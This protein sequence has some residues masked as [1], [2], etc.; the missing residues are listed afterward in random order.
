MTTNGLNGNHLRVLSVL[1]SHLE[2]QLIEMETTLA[3]SSPSRFA[4][5]EPDLDPDQCEAI[6]RHIARLRR[7]MDEGARVLGLE[8]ASGKK[9]ASWI[10][11]NTLTFMSIALEEDSPEA[12][13]GYGAL[14]DEAAERV[15]RIEA[16]LEE[17]IRTCKELVR[18]GTQNRRSIIPDYGRVL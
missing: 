12:L 4:E 15:A 9:R 10:V 18:D 16:E 2:K 13:R 3:S 17:T 8:S 11:Q 14:S 1:F 7:Q 5:V 6:E